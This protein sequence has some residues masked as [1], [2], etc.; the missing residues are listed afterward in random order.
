MRALSGTHAQGNRRLA[1]A[2]AMRLSP[3]PPSALLPSPRLHPLQLHPA[4]PLLSS[5]APPPLLPFLPS[6][7][8]PSPPYP[9]RSHVHPR[10]PIR[11]CSPTLFAFSSLSSCAPAADPL[12]RLSSLSRSSMLYLQFRCPKATCH[13]LCLRARGHLAASRVATAR[14]RGFAL[15][16]LALC[17]RGDTLARRLALLHA[18]ARPRTTSALAAFLSLH[19]PDSPLASPLSPCRHRL[20]KTLPRPTLPLQLLRLRSTRS[21]SLP[22]ET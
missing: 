9:S 13:C 11:R 4:R 19:R 22:R 12:L 7:L 17:P 20:R 18:L 3:P 21:S 10:L 2:A 6:S 1:F 15:S 14:G 16:P 5:P 8:S